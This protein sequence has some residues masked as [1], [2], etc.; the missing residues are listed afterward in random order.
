MADRA[1]RGSADETAADETANR[2]GDGPGEHVVKDRVIVKRTRNTRTRSGS[3]LSADLIVDAAMSL[4]G[5]HGA[6]ALSVRRLGTA[7]GCDPTA[8]YRYF[9]SMDALMLAVAD[10]LIGQALANYQPGGDWKENLRSLARGTYNAYL[11][12]PR[13]AIA[14]AARI[15]GGEHE[16][17]II[18]L[19]LGELR[20]AGFEG[21]QAVRLYRSFGDFIL[22]FSAVDADYL[23]RPV[24][25]RQA[26]TQRWQ[27]AYAAVDA[28][29]YPHLAVLGPVVVQH[30]GMSTFESCLALLLDTFE[31]LAPR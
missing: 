16:T 29:S 14:V 15:T 6:A 27:D 8:V 9:A 28:A 12:N 1:A 26:D 24:Q 22:A 3:V 21:E 20:T 17:R 5:E 23:A 11:A 7:L 25:Q 4:I 10:R 13:V 30:A 2:A 19:V 31:R 18:D